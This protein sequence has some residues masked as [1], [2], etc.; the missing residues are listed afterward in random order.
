MKKRVFTI[1]LAG[2][3]ALT[4]TAVWAGSSENQPGTAAAA[5]AEESTDAITAADQT[6]AGTTGTQSATDST[7][8][9]STG[10]QSTA[11]T[12]DA[13]AAGTQVK[14][15]SA[16]TDSAATGSA[17]TDSTVSEAAGAQSS[18]N[19]AGADAAA[20]KAQTESAAD[21]SQQTDSQSTALAASAEEDT[22]LAGS[23][24]GALNADAGIDTGYYYIL[25]NLD[26][27]K[28]LDI[29]GASTASGA[30]AQ[31]YSFNKSGAQIYYVENYG[32]GLY[33]IMN[34]NSGK[35]LDVSGA[36]TANFT[37]VWQ[38]TDNGSQAQRW[39]IGASADEGCC[40]IQASY[41]NK[42]LDVF[43]GIS[44]NQQNVQI[45]TSNNSAAQQWK[46]VQL[47]D[48]AVIKDGY[49]NI[50][51]LLSQDR[52]LGIAGDSWINLANAE[53]EKLTVGDAGEVFYI[54][55]LG[56]GYYSFESCLSGKVLDIY[57]NASSSGTNLDQY[58][59]SGS[60]A[61]I[62]YV[63]NSSVSGYYTIAKGNLHTLAVDVSGGDTS[64]G[65][66]VQM[67]T[68]NG[69]AAQSWKFIP[70]DE[71]NVELPD[72]VYTLGSKNDRSALV[73]VAGESSDD[74]A[75]VQLEQD[76]GSEYQE[77]IV[78]KNSSGYYS[79]ICMG[80][81]KA[82]DVR[83]NSSADFANVWQYIS[84]STDAQLWKVT[85][86]RGV[87]RFEGKG[88]GKYLDC[89]GGRTEDGTNIQIYTGNG[90]KAQA[91][92]MTQLN[93]VSSGRP[94]TYAKDPATGKIFKTEIEFLTDPQV[95]TDISENDLLAG[96]LYTEA[97]D[98]GVAGMMM[99]GYV[100]ETRMQEGITAA[101]NND[102]IEYPGTLAN[103]IYE[104]QQWQVARDGALTDCLNDIV[105]GNASYLS[106]ARSAAAKV[107]NKENIT[108]EKDA[109]LYTE[110]SATTS[111]SKVLPSG[112]VIKPSDFIYNSFMTPNSWNKYA[113]DGKHP[114][115]TSGYG[116][117]KN[118]FVYPYY[119]GGHVFFLDSEVW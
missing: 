111:S 64:E 28:A 101:K 104:W 62:F 15:G 103:M 31:I 102:Y 92:Y 57:G 94:Y 63:S 50:I 118:T 97:G 88:S 100:I 21:G 10:T 19:S 89:L 45:Y 113:A 115:F 41:T 4:P 6:A 18:T 5:A 14:T 108:L 82:L 96:V 65:T 68:A 34:K 9:E 86:C 66:N 44:A 73:S 80:S 72:G 49:Y 17:A 22:A 75:N 71:P 32:N 93:L 26:Q 116:S 48:Q 25:S 47:A 91:F 117:G 95:G 16:A 12:A 43:G 69:T 40:T 81:K 39:Y 7:A 60:E 87:Y 46:F 2:M 13:Q 106:K 55:N 58:D 24:A 67:Y 23:Y 36:G 114:N 119:A 11:D 83:G 20:A 78:A 112:T 109:T 105:N 74:C 99:V 98:Q 53:L 35:M 3:L 56:E 76:R 85:G 84:N 1:I 54:H 59:S 29:S 37:N 27:S 90:S 33:S 42:V 8:A 61:Q 110:T 52:C 51:S 79:I 77:F 70:T 30:N 107:L 38:Y